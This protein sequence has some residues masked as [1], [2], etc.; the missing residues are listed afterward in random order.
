[1]KY[2]IDQKKFMKAIRLLLLTSLIYCQ[3]AFTSCNYNADIK[4]SD[5]VLLNNSSQNMYKHDFSLY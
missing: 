4:Q 5:N 2:L 3:M 1:M